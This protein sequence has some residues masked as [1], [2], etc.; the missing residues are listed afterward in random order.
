MQPQKKAKTEKEVEKE[1]KES[2]SKWFPKTEFTDFV[3][4]ITSNGSTKLLFLS[5]HNLH[6]LRSPVVDE[7]IKEKELTVTDFPAKA[8]EDV[9][10]CM[11]PL[12]HPG[13]LRKETIWYPAD[14]DLIALGH[15]LHIS[16]LEK[17]ACGFAKPTR[18]AAEFLA[19]HHRA[20]DAKYVMHSMRIDDT[21]F[22]R[23][24]S[25]YL[26]N[27]KEEWVPAVYCYPTKTDLMFCRRG[28]EHV[29]RVPKLN[30][31][32][33]V[34]FVKDVSIDQT[35]IGEKIEDAVKVWTEAKN[36][37]MLQLVAEM[38]LE[39]DTKRSFKP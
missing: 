13:F 7:W 18:E 6:Q 36:F 5:R 27:E 4:T 11:L 39:D 9:F 30:V 35:E 38:Y 25:Y 31:R 29:I 37:L 26:Q 16:F 32:Q 3:L 33:S 34:R 17:I 21:Q 19:Q 28:V 14:R 2:E 1:E 22:R 8:Y 10:R 24:L 20:Q 23:G 12:V 15:K